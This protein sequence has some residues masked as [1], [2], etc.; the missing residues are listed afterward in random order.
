MMEMS[1]QIIDLL[2][3]IQ[4]SHLYG[5]S[6]LFDCEQRPFEVNFEQIIHTF[7][8][9]F[10]AAYIGNPIFVSFNFYWNLQ[11]QLSVTGMTFVMKI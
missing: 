10:V 7:I 9:S 1:A 3:E 5:K 4:F 11:H 6:L 8:H 2:N